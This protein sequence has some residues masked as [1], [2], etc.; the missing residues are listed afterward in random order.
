[1]TAVEDPNTPFLESPDIYDAPSGVD[2]SGLF[3]F[4][5]DARPC[6]SSCMAYLGARPEGADYQGQQWAKCSL[7]VSLHKVGKHAVA[8]A[9]QGDA[10][11]RH[12]R[13]KTADQARSAQTL[14]PQVR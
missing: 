7:L 12:L 13:I 14:P 9:G 3:C 4:I 8:L 10:L 6:S 2:A 11:L 1:M 5:N